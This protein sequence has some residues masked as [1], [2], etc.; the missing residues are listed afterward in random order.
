MVEDLATVPALSPV[1]LVVRLGAVALVTKRTLEDLVV[2][3]VVWATTPD[4]APETNTESPCPVEVD[5]S[6]IGTLV[7]IPLLTPS[8]SAESDPT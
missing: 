7:L 2:D 5:L 8:E 3:V 1:L 4:L 6:L